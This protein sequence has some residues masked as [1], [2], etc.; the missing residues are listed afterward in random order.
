MNG[1]KINLSVTA[2]QIYNAA[3]RTPIIERTAS[4]MSCGLARDAAAHNGGL[5]IAGQLR[6][7]HAV[8]LPELHVL[9]S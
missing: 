5:L 8:P 3:I 6:S 4:A 9:F 1:L 7:Q 2:V